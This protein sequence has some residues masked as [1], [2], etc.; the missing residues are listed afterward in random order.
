VSAIRNRNDCKA[1]ELQD[2]LPIARPE[3]HLAIR[4]EAIANIYII[5]NNF[6]K[7]VRFAV[8]TVV[9]MNNAVFCDATPCGSCKN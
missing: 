2:S 6:R 9:T 4:A 1:S 8:F 5:L 3:F 7:Y